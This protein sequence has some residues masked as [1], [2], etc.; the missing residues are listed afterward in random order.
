MRLH[1]ARGNPGPSRHDLYGE[2]NPYDTVPAR[3]A[4]ATFELSTFAICAG[5]SLQCSR[6]GERLP[7]ISSAFSVQGKRVSNRVFTIIL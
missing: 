3:S 6:E 5:L 4:P 7:I 2:A 1:V